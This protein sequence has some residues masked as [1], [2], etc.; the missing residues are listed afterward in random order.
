MGVVGDT[1]T[2]MSRFGNSSSSIPVQQRRLCWVRPTSDE[3]R[4]RLKGRRTKRMILFTLGLFGRW[5]LAYIHEISTKLSS[6]RE[7]WTKGGKWEWKDRE[8]MN[9]GEECFYQWKY[10]S[11]CFYYGKLFLNSLSPFL[12]VF[13]PSLILSYFIFSNHPYLCFCCIFTSSSSL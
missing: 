7:N 8:R 6:P 11:L 9:S 2:Q 1:R 13:L 4:A 12:A 5:E 10:T 3:P